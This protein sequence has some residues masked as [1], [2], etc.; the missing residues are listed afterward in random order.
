MNTYSD[1][2]S[3]FGCSSTI[4]TNF[5]RSEGKLAEVL[6]ALFSVCNHVRGAFDAIEPKLFIRSDIWNELEF[7]NKSHWVGK[8]LDL[9]WSPD[10]LAALMLKRA[11]AAKPIQER[12][13]RAL[14]QLTG[15]GAVE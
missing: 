4:S 2:V 7:T 9:T 15:P 13:S 11:V 3:A 6:S 14:P 12:L 5:S 1:K 8:R 10:Q